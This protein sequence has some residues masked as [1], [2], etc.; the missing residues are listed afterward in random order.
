MRT[1]WT[2]FR[3]VRGFVIAMII[4]FAAILALGLTPMSGTCT[5]QTCRQPV[6]PAG[7]EVRD[8]FYLLHRPLT[9]DGSL[10]ARLTS[11]TGRIPDIPADEGDGDDGGGRAA[12][13]AAGEGMRDGLV[14]WAKAGL[15]I[16]DGTERGSAYA[17][18]MMTGGHGVRMQHDFVHD[19]SAQPET[20]GAPVPTWLR[21]TRTGDVI[22][23]ESSADGV[24]WTRVAS[25]EL[26]GLP[27]TVRIGLFATSP[28]FVEATGVAGASSGPS[29]VTATFDDISGGVAGWTG[30]GV[31]GDGAHQSTGTGFTLTGSGDIGPA[32][33]G[34]AGLGVSITQTLLGTFAGLVLVVVVGAAFMTG[35]YRRGMIRTT[36]AATPDRGRVLFAKAAVLG[37]VTFVVGLAGAAIVVVLGRRLL[38]GNGVYVLPSTLLTEVRVIT[39]TAA[40]LAVAAV[41]ALGIGAMLR[42]SAVAISAVVGLIVLPYLLALTVLPAAAADWLLRVT[43]AAA[44]AVQQSAKQ[45]YQVENLYTPVDGYFPLPW[46]AG[47]GVLCLWAGAALAGAAVLLRRRDV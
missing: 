36:L 8:S 13:P 15:I 26:D 10:T 47:F 24:N 4:A 34:A 37:G 33:V 14:A 39:G 3:T 7:E 45:F 35:E 12:G 18:V 19:R 1:E 27:S 29:S 28:Q 20:T 31:G 16:K 25:V 21:L 5:E 38:V 11:M 22:T 46:W 41:L 23:G 17:A 30:Q 9:G 42:R 40:L 6:G 44:F 32:V 2:K 43:P